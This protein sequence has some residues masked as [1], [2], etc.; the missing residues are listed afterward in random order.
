MKLLIY[1]IIFALAFILYLPVFIWKLVRRGGISGRFLERFGIYGAERKRLLRSLDRPIW[2]HA[3]SVGEVVAA[4]TFIRRWQQEQPRLTFVLST[5]TTTGQATAQ[6][7]L[8]EGVA[9]IYCPLDFYLPVKRVLRLVQ[10]AMLVIFEVE[11]WPNLISLATA[12]GTPVVLTNGRMSDRSAAGYARHRWFFGPLFKKFEV[13]C[14]QSKEDALRV[15]GVVDDSVPVHVCNTM[16]FDQVPDVSGADKTKLLDDVFGPEK[17]LVWTAASTH[18]GEESLAASTYLRLKARC[19]ELKMI[20]VPRHH[21]RTSEAEKALTDQGLSYRLLC[22]AEKSEPE[23]GSVDVLLVNTTGELMNFYAVSDV[24]FVGKSLAG[25][26]GGHN[27]IEPAIFGKAIV[28]GAAMQNFR[29]VAKVF[30]DENATI[31]V[32]DDAGLFEVTCEL[33]ADTDQRHELGR[34]ARIVVEEW[35]GAIDRTLTHLE[36]LLAERD[37]S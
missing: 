31:E 4:L 18:P 34:R 7:K 24:V 32:A 36:P 19:P 1:N 23:S 17:R 28:H 16:K 11:V 33:L 9:L 21:E 3:V 26:E 10:P 29:A 22:P 20:L 30:R 6:K 5:T 35:R 27:I 2:V 37:S 13:I 14:V 25:N 15:Q 12:S 8:P